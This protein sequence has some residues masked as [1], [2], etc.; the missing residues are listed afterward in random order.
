MFISRVGYGSDT[1]INIGTALTWVYWLF[2]LAAFA[3]LPAFM[4]ME[5][6]GRPFC[7]YHDR[8]YEKEKSLGGVEPAQ[9]ENVMG[10]LSG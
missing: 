7:V 9:A 2:D 5:A 8:W 1:G 6:A 3:G 10:L 4:A